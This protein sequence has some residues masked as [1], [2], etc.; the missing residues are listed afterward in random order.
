M[1]I[2]YFLKVLLQASAN[3]CKPCQLLKPIMEKVILNH[4]Q[5]DDIYWTL[6]MNL[7]N[8]IINQNFNS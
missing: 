2:L 6:F 3:W 8:I 7:I 5:K 1:W 4:K